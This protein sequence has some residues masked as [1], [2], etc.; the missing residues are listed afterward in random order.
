MRE[1]IW[2]EAALKAMDYPIKFVGLE[3]VAAFADGLLQ[4]Y[5]SRFSPVCSTPPR[6]EC[7]IGKEPDFESLVTGCRFEGG[8]LTLEEDKDGVILKFSKGESP[9]YSFHMPENGLE[10]CRVWYEANKQEFLKEIM[11]SFNAAEEL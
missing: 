4:E 3:Q 1:A 9:S 10:A 5:D 11:E 8:E 2:R 6:E 7:R